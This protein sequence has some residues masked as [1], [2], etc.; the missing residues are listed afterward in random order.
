[1]GRAGISKDKQLLELNESTVKRLWRK[2]RPNPHRRSAHTL[3]TAIVTQARDP[4]FFLSLEVPDSVDGRFD[5]ISLHMFL[6]LRRLRHSGVEADEF[7]QTL[8]DTFFADMD[9]SLREMGVGDLG[10]G[11]KVR[12]MSKAFM[13]RVDAYDRSLDAGSRQELIAALVRNLYRGEQPAEA[14][15]ERLADYIDQATEVLAALPV[16]RIMGG[17]VDFGKIPG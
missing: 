17:T 11:K 4:G 5:M 8:F 1:M 6:V 9:R 3:Y 2:A 10:V 12:A 13:G 16:E 7:A 15:L 14:V